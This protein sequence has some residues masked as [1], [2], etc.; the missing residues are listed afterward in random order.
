MLRKIKILC[1]ISMMFLLTGCVKLNMNMDIKND[2]SMDLSIL[3]AVDTTV[4]GEEELLKEEDI[5]EY[6]DAGFEVKD[7][8]EGNYKGIT[9]KKHVKNIDKISK[10]TGTVSFNIMGSSNDEDDSMF[11]V[12]KGFFKNVYTLK[13]K[14]DSTGEMTNGIDDS[15][16]R[17]ALEDEDDT[18]LGDYPSDD[19]L[20]DDYSD[21]G[22]TFDDVDYTQYLSQMDLSLVVNLP[23][24]P[25]SHNATNVS[26]D[27]KSLTW[28]LATQQEDVELTFAL[29]NLSNIFVCV[30]GV[31]VVVVGVVI[32]IAKS[33]KNKNG[34]NNQVINN[35]QNANMNNTNEV[36]NTNNEQNANMNNSNEVNNTNNEVREEIQPVT[37]NEVVNNGVN[38][39]PNEIVNNEQPT[40]NEQDDIFPDNQPN[41]EQNGDSSPLEDLFNNNPDN[42]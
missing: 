5:A 13:M 24:K 38:T 32:V 6:K 10:T 12:K 31:I 8:S 40:V 30:L 25:I 34:S 37:N 33:G 2:K 18:L 16:G 20:L 42:N 22:Y 35:E 39:I 9:L 17:K 14:S 15:D 29:Y 27:G 28:N 11:T 3:Y 26:N 1:I 4:L 41:T 23:N 21:D 7:Y 19:S 36:N